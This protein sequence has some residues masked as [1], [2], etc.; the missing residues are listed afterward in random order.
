M[1]GP[2]YQQSIG[3]TFQI[4]SGKETRILAEPYFTTSAPSL[5][6]FQWTINNANLSTGSEQPGILSYVTEAGSR[7]QQ[8]ATLEITNSFNIVERIRKTF[9]IHVE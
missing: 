6:Q 9:R 8:I 5:L 3:N 7:G 4:A 2:L 1:Q